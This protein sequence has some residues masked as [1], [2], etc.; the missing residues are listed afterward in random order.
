MC[1]A[2]ACIPMHPGCTWS[3][4]HRMVCEARDILKM[5]LE[6]R[7][8]WMADLEKKRGDISVLKNEILRQFNERKTTRSGAQ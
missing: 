5:P 3:E 7:R 1:G 8:S 2:S 4:Q 6:K